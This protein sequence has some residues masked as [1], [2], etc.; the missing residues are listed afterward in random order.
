MAEHFTH[1]KSNFTRETYWHKQTMHGAAV[2]NTNSHHQMYRPYS[3]T[4]PN[5]TLTYKVMEEHSTCLKCTNYLGKHKG[6]IL[7]TY[8]QPTGQPEVTENLYQTTTVTLGAPRGLI[9]NKIVLRVYLVLL[10]GLLCGRE[11]NSLVTVAHLS[12]AGM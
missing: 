6:I 7:L 8:E 9:Q 4:M 2:A 12:I 10:A 5:I 11:I 1:F 3:M